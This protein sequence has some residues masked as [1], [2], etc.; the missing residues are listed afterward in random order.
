MSLPWFKPR[1]LA[2]ES[3]A[4]TMRPPRYKHLLKAGKLLPV[5]SEQTE[6]MLQ[7]PS[8]QLEI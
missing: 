6:N 4:L 7:A 2:L 1:P 5:K 3:S 8:I